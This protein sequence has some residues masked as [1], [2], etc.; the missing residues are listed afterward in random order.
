MKYN[1]TPPMIMISI[2]MQRQMQR[3]LAV[4]CVSFLLMS[5]GTANA[6][7]AFDPKRKK[8]SIIYPYE[9][10]LSVAPIG[11]IFIHFFPLLK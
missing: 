10:V 2:G 11:T 1:P 8:L 3:S 7:I 5:T 9:V 6:F 4:I